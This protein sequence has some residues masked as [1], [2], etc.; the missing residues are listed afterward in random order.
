MTMKLLRCIFWVL[1]WFFTSG[2]VHFPI[3]LKRF[4]PSTISNVNNLGTVLKN[5]ERF[6]RYE[7]I[8]HSDESAHPLKLNPEED[9]YS[10]LEVHPSADQNALKKAYYKLVIKYHP[11]NKSSSAEKDLANRQMMIINTAYRCLKDPIFRKEYDR[12]RRGIHQRE[13]YWA[14]EE[15]RD[16]IERPPPASSSSG[17]D[18]EIS[19]WEFKEFLEDIYEKPFPENS[20]FVKELYARLQND[21]EFR[22]NIIRNGDFKRAHQQGQRT[23]SSP[24][25][26]AYRNQERYPKSDRG[27]GSISSLQL[28]LNSLK[29]QYASK[30]SLLQADNRDWGDVKDI[31]IIRAR[32]Q[33]VDE[34]RL[35]GREIEL[36]MDEIRGLQA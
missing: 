24:R 1:C 3:I 17:I 15:P 11:D 7:M 32:L 25:H 35:I 36:V 12:R 20:V 31:D 10:V 6:R 27:D 14:R 30:H 28:H 29:E 9:F 8:S 33:A 16:S 26:T 18:I 4:D 13:S 34:L 23:E 19:F 22:A 2:F 5:G 21:P